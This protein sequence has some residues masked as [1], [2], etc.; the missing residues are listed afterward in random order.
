MLAKKRLI[1]SVAGLAL[2]ATGVTYV[3]G[4]V[5]TDSTALRN[6][7]TLEGVRAHQAA[8]QGIAD[9]NG[10]TRVAGAPGHDASADYV[11]NLLDAAGYNV[12]KQTFTFPFFEEN[13][14]AQFGQT[15]PAIIDYSDPADFSTMTY[16]GSGNIVNGVVKNAAGIIAPTPEPSSVSGCAATDFGPEISGNVALIQRG[17]CTFAEKA[18]NAQNAGAIAVIIFNEGN[19]GREDNFGGTLGGTGFKI[20][21]ISTSYVIGSG[22]AALS[23]PQVRIFTDTTSTDL[24]TVNVIAESPGGRSDRVVVVGAHLDSVA[25]GPGIN[26]NGS[27]SAAILE[28]ALQMRALGINPRNK[29]RFAWW[30]AEEAGL[31]GSEHYVSQLTKRQI[32]DIAVNI[33]FDMIGSPNFVRQV[34]DGDGSDTPDAGPNGSAIIEDVFNKYFRKQRLSFEA[35]A[36]D[37][38]SD[39]GPFIDAGIPAGGLFTGAEE[40]KTAA[41][42]ALF[43]GT[44]GVALDPCYHQ[45]C[46][47]FAN[48][49]NTALDQM[50][51]AAADAVLQFA[52]T[53]SAVKGTSKAN[54]Q[55]VKSVDAESLLYKGSHL[56]R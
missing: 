18:T 9:V 24:P 10:G 17:S 3:M 29:V 55:A 30:S 49:S 34:Y 4:A 1:T 36:F 53:T 12:S 43:G 37:G 35:T 8:L 16:S 20:P 46:D 50:S 21:V 7:V 11:Y 40:L 33:N 44:A 31:L 41:Q 28:I 45:A 25:E 56:Q 19:P 51:D 15:Q 38:R 14:P 13:S 26:D 54:D 23:N 42:E 52:M 39:Y 22:L 6:A 32:R 5:G 2:M 27:G 47:T 48:N